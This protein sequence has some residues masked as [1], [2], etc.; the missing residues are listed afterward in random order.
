MTE[1]E[2]MQRAKMYMDKL[3]QGID[4]FTGR[5][6]PNDTVLNDLRLARCFFYVS[7]VLGQTINNGGTVVKKPK[8]TDFTITPEQLAAVQIS[9]E[10][11]QVTQLVDAI[12]G[13]INDPQMKKLKTTV[14]TD[15]LVEKGFLAKKTTPEGK[16]QRVPTPDG[17][18]LG[19]YT[20]TRQGQYGEYEAVFYNQEAQRFIL[21]H[22]PTILSE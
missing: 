15:W 13:A 8:K 11:V 7:G 5:E 9:R 17:Q 16:N 1:I 6:L 21:D 3:A 12:S 20:Q 22:L 2:I 10:P 19:L 18:L 14:I 4:P